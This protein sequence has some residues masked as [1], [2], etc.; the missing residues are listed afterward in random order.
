MLGLA[1]GLTAVLAMAS[2]A[3]AAPLSDLQISR[4]IENRLSTDDALENVTVSVQTSV[5]SLSGTAYTVARP[6]LGTQEGSDVIHSRFSVGLSELDQTSEIVRLKHQ[7]AQQVGTCRLPRAQASGQVTEEPRQPGLE[8]AR[9]F[10]EVLRGSDDNRRQQRAAGVRET[11]GHGAKSQAVR[12]RAILALLSEK[13]IPEAAAKCGISERTLHRWLTSDAAFQA[14]YAAARQAAF[15]AGIHRVQAL[16]A[17]AVD[18]LEELLGEKKHPNVRLGAART[19]AEL[20]LHQH[21]ADTIL[22]KLDEIETAQRQQDTTGT[23]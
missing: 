20:S 6:V 21:D 3:A 15:E 16:T 8:V 2:I 11:A 5:V 9:E 18:T 17:R 4:Q 13:T 12:D 1:V 22:R 23:W 14:D 19:V 7:Q 10:A